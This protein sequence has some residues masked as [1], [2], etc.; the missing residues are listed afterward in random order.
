MAGYEDDLAADNAVLETLNKINVL[1]GNA[2][3]SYN[4]RSEPEKNELVNSITALSEKIETLITA[5]NQTGEYT[6]EVNVT[7]ADGA[8]HELVSRVIEEVVIR[9]RQENLLTI[10]SA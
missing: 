8:I 10:T 9:I 5:L 6:V 1:L 7:G 3:Q 2:V 4:N